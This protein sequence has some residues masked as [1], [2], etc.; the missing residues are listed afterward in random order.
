M[1]SIQAFKELGGAQETLINY[2]SAIY[3]QNNPIPSAMVAL[4]PSGPVQVQLQQQTE[5]FPYQHIQ[6]ILPNI[7]TQLVARFA[8]SIVLLLTFIHNH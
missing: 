1:V 8:F 3:N 4:P 6:P 2:I 7:G 5:G